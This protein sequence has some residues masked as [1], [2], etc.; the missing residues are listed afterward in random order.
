MLNVLAAVVVVV[1]W[2]L[3]CLVAWL[4]GCLV[5]WLLGCLVARCSCVHAHQIEAKSLTT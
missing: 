1:G 5:A 2:L 4:L 3:G